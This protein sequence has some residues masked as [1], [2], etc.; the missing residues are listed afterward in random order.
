MS[1]ALRVVLYVVLALSFGLILL[2]VMSSGEQSTLDRYYPLLLTVNSLMI[3]VLAILSG[4][5][6][7]RAW[8]RGRRGVFGSRLMIRLT[9]ALAI[10][11]V[12]P[13]LFLALVSVQFLGKTI[14]SWFAQS[15]DTALEAGAA[16][17][18]TTLQAS[19]RDALQNAE[20][21][22][23]VL[24]DVPDSQLGIVL[25]QL[26]GALGPTE[27]TVMTPSSRVLAIRS[28]S[29]FQLVPDSP[30]REALS[31]VAKEGR[32]VI[33]EPQTSGEP[34]SL[35][36][37][38]LVREE[39]PIRGSREVRILQWRD[40]VPASLAKSIEDLTVGTSDYRQLVLSKEGIQQVYGVSLTLT[41]L[42]GLFGALTVSVLLSYWLAG[43]L[44]ALEQATRAVGKGDYPKLTAT[45]G[46]HEINDLIHA[47]N[48]MTD[49]LA[50]AH[51]E[52]VDSQARQAANNRFLE[53]LLAHLSAG[54]VV[55]SK[56]WQVL[57]FN[58]SAL[59]ILGGEPP[60]PGAPFRQFPGLGPFQDSIAAALDQQPEDQRQLDVLDSRGQPRVLLVNSSRLPMGDGGEQAPRA[61]E[62]VI[63][64][65][66]VTD[67]MAAERARAWTDMARRLAHEIK[68]PL[69][70]IQL[71]AERLVK[72]LAPQ[73]E[74]TN[75][76]LLQKSCCT[77]VE[78]V[79]ALKTMVDEF[80]SYARLPLAQRKLLDLSAVVDD[81]RPLF[82]SDKRV[83][84][85]SPQGVMAEIDRNQIGQVLHNLILNAQE[86]LGDAPGLVS[87]RVSARD[88]IGPEGVRA[89]SAVLTVEDTGP[90]LPAEIASRVF[91]PYVSSKSRG[92]GLGLAIVKKIADEHETTVQ[93]QTI[94]GENGEPQGTRAELQFASPPSLV[95]NPT[96]GIHPDR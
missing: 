22:L 68:N 85:E 56:D 61:G 53:A 8:S 90:G 12:V 25:S 69:T 64:F 87:V 28:E 17:G 4:L 48:R 1:L 7:V 11:G 34:G 26:G 13:L 38:A 76:E 9:A 31:I 44:R 71:S 89:R 10:M 2:L 77:I 80:R 14:D 46:D 43:P 36:I 96:Y 72:R 15:V 20:Q 18:R 57:E 49:Q 66:D 29:G 52:A 60:A 70:P 75:A 16:L 84:F 63:V 21:L 27:V 50:E 19:Q 62:V 6:L 91:D 3:V 58:Y 24:R 59:M 93:L 65:D 78:Q 5:I 94:L 86:A 40:P 79:G 55:V 95:N 51:N 83:Q 41:V 45:T 54:V 39:Q 30:T 33:V 82:A 47:F 81:L 74:G 88:T 42:L 23:T 92:S 35:Q 67:L 32:F 73:L 37:R